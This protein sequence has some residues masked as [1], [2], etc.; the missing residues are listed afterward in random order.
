[1]VTSVAGAQ[2]ASHEKDGWTMLQKTAKCCIF[3]NPTLT[4]FL[5]TGHFGEA[6]FK[7]GKLELRERTDS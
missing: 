6:E 3:P 5:Q 2:E 7:A 4:D 1:M